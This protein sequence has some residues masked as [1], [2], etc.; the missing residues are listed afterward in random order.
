MHVALI[1][2]V[3]KFGLQES[4]VLDLATK[5]EIVVHFTGDDKF[6]IVEGKMYAFT[7]EWRNGKIS[8]TRFA[9]R[10]FLDPMYETDLIEAAGKFKLINPINDPFVE[11]YQKFMEEYLNESTEESTEIP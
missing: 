3:L 11:Y 1:G 8:L 2:T 5:E 4:L 9:L 7:G 10:R 6:D